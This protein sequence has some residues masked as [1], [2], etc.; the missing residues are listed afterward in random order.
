MMINTPSID[1]T[2]YIF[3]FMLNECGG[4]QNVHMNAVSNMCKNIIIYLHIQYVEI[5]KSMKNV[6]SI[7][8]SKSW[9]MHLHDH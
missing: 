1:I 9:Y 7:S 4:S 2:S 5:R 6:S 8:G 3:I